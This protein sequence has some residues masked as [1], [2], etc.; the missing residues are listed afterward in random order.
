MLDIHLLAVRQSGVNSDTREKFAP[1]KWVCCS[2]PFEKIAH[3]S[4]MR[5]T[6]ISTHKHMHSDRE[7]EKSKKWDKDI[8]KS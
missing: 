4:N 8:I 2:K 1:A 6:L 3:M 5:H 7:R